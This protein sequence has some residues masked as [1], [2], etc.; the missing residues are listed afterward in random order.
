MVA[1]FLECKS[2]SLAR[3]TGEKREKPC[4]KSTRLYS[5]GGMAEN[6]EDR[7]RTEFRH[8]MHSGDLLAYL[9]LHLNRFLFSRLFCFDST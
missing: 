1:T 5:S 6:V 2:A 4:R 7:S 9:S 3:P 8:R